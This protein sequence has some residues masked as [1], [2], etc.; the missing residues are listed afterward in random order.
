M[1]HPPLRA[2]LLDMDDTLCDTRSANA[3]AK[4]HFTKFAPSLL[5]PALDA[6]R[7]AEL[8]LEAI[9]RILPEDLRHLD[10]LKEEKEYRN[11][12]L[13]ALAPLCGAAE[14]D[15]AT[16]D[17]LRLTFEESRLAA[18]DFFP[19]T[20]EM[21]KRLRHRFRLAVITN[22]PRYSQQP[23][24]ERVHMSRHVDTILIGGDFPHEKPHPSIFAGALEHL[25]VS[26]SDAVH[27]GDSLSA[28]IAGARASGIRSVWICPDHHAGQHPAGPDAVLRRITE[29]EALLETWAR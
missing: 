6:P 27:V 9:Y 14:P 4:T 12:C 19:G 11:C 26:A 5:G 24:L 8:Y 15:A 22:G 29:L 7:Y 18:Y 21:L 2:V 23:K 16:A 3:V 17:R 10:A 28:D 13:R 25:Q 20:V 1:T